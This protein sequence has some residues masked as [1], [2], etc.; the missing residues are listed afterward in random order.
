M[1]QNQR[2]NRA[3]HQLAKAR[4]CSLEVIGVS[5]GNLEISHSKRHLSNLSQGM[6]MWTRERQLSS[7]PLHVLLPVLL[8]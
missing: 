1:W 3:S 6:G 5:R 8:F 7:E 2:G 4:M